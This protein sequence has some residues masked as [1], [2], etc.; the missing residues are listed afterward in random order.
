[1]DLTPDYKW[2]RDL[3]NELVNEESANNNI[4]A[5][6]ERLRPLYKEWIED[7]CNVT[8][9]DNKLPGPVALALDELVKND[10]KQY[11]I[12]SE[13]LSDMSVTYG[14]ASGGSAGAGAIPAYIMAWLEPYR[15]M[16]NL[17]KDR[18][19]YDDGRR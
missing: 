7:Y 10:P 3:D 5:E 8:F 15:R 11:N 19:P 9:E 17:E 12:Q 4:E 2:E 14:T 16:N 18:R 13:K 1:M 6:F